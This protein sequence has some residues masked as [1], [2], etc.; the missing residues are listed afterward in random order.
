[1]FKMAQRR[2][3]A[4]RIRPYK[5]DADDSTAIL[6][7][8][9]PVQDVQM[10]YGVVDPRAVPI[11]PF[12]DFKNDML[13]KHI[14]RDFNVHWRPIFNLMDACPGLHRDDPN[15]FDRGMEYLKT[16]VQYVFEK[17]KA[18][19]TQ[20]ELS[21][22]SKHVRHSSIVKHGTESDKDVA[23]GT[24]SLQ[25]GTQYRK[26]ETKKEIGGTT[27]VDVGNHREDSSAIHT[28]AK[29]KMKTATAMRAIMQMRIFQHEQDQRQQQQGLQWQQQQGLQ[30]QQQ[31]LPQTSRTQAPTFWTA[32]SLHL[33][34]PTK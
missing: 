13:P 21:T 20:W 5:R 17:S 28:K 9:I 30:G 8:I 12:P 31:G 4:G 11:R 10:H 18:N 14:Q 3:A 2:Q 22:W 27:G 25:Q 6:G 19:P 15:S 33:V 29:T 32:W 16:R 7:A 34:L 1:L 23:V 24:N 26:V